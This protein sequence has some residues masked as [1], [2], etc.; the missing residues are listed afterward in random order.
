M[1][2]IALHPVILSVSADDQRLIRRA[3]VEALRRRARQA[4]ALSARYGGYILSE[5]EKDEAGVP[6]PSN[7]FYWS[8]SHKERL[9]AAVVSP[10][11]VG[12]DLERLTSVPIALI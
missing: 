3:K 2:E 4:A 12:I 1:S 6:L 7:G 10:R 8:L 11:P 5:L 9:V